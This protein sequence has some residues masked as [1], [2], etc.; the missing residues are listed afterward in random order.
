DT[1]F[2]QQTNRRVCSLVEPYMRREK[3]LIRREEHGW[4]LA[5]VSPV[6][7][8]MGASDAAT[9][10]CPA[11]TRRSRYHCALV[12]PRAHRVGLHG[13]LARR[14]RLRGPTRARNSKKRQSAAAGSV[15]VPRTAG[16]AMSTT[17]TIM[18][19][20]MACLSTGPL[21]LAILMLVLLRDRA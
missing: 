20:L 15:C 3:R 2:D 6:T 14:L 5:S 7:P 11:H 9:I 21:L 12:A 1:I 13:C 4:S 18:Q 8:S 16:T 17:A 19:W 10:S